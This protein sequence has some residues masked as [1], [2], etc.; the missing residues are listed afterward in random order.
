M[1]Q[2]DPGLGA[3][4]II[5]S[6]EIPFHKV[7]LP[8]PRGQASHMS[9][10]GHCPTI[11]SPCYYP[12]PPAYLTG[13]LEVNGSPAGPEVASDSH[14]TTSVRCRS[15]VWS[16]LSAMTAVTWQGQNRVSDLSRCW[17]TGGL[18]VSIQASRCEL[19]VSARISH[20]TPGV[21]LLSE[22]PLVYSAR[23]LCYWCF[24]TKCIP[25]RPSKLP[26]GLY[27]EK[28]AFCCI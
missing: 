12:P 6:A 24:L 28:L 19:T 1:I 25:T 8:S 5:T 22:L 16:A 18:S 4:S 9:F 10:G 23:P 7:T 3:S 11:L 17:E 27:P 15:G 21:L 14:P 13:L 26:R 20:L 2:D